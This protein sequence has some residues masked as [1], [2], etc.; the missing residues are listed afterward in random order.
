MGQRRG[1]GAR[2]GACCYRAGTAGKRERAAAS[3]AEPME[4]C[5]GAEPGARAGAT[6][7]APDAGDPAPA[8]ATKV[9]G[10]LCNGSDTGS[11]AAAARRPC[12]GA[13]EADSAAGGAAVAPEA[14]DCLVYVRA[15]AAHACQGGGRGG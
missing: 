14:G 1:V 12:A 4:L 3:G 10:A 9:D 13:A 11:G 15:R 8:K 7:P 6:G 5:G 2:T